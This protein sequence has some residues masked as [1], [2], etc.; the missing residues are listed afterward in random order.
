M[1]IIYDEYTGG[2]YEVEAPSLRQAAEDFAKDGLRHCLS[3][4]LKEDTKFVPQV[5]GALRFADEATLEG[6]GKGCKFEG[7]M[8]KT[9]VIFQIFKR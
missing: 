3:P 9:Q 2:L 4:V 1:F 8:P 5:S 7:Q 6:W